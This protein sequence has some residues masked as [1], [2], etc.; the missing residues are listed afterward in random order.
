MA[1]VSLST[2]DKRFFFQDNSGVLREALYTSATKTWA[3]DVGNMV[4]NNAKNN[5]PIAALL[6]NGTGASTGYMVGLCLHLAE[7]L[8]IETSP[9][10]TFST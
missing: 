2:G 8:L 7:T 10:S 4:A 1:A 5:T 6:V 3:A 9:R